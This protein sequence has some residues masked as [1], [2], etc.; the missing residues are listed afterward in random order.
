M[1]LPNR[2]QYIP[3][4]AEHKCIKGTADP[5]DFGILRWTK[6]HMA[7][8]RS[9]LYFRVHRQTPS[10]DG[11]EYL[12]ERSV[13]RRDKGH[14]SAEFNLHSARLAYVEPIASHLDV[15]PVWEFACFREL[16]VNRCLTDR[17]LSNNSTWT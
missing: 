7:A 6:G 8:N 1:S 2:S 5:S 17:L 14:G 12:F 13:R 10:S 11:L 3:S 4:H 9:T 16:T 15:C